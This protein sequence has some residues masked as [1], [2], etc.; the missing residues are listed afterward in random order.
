MRRRKPGLLHQHSRCTCHNES[1]CL[2]TRRTDDS[3]C[4]VWSVFCTNVDDY[5]D[6]M[7]NFLSTVF[8]PDTKYL[9]VRTFIEMENSRLQLRGTFVTETVTRLWPLCQRE[10]LFPFYQSGGSRNTYAYLVKIYAHI[11]GRRRHGS[12]QC[13]KSL[14]QILCIDWSG[15][16]AEFFFMKKKTQVSMP[17]MCYEIRNQLINDNSSVNYIFQWW[18]TISKIP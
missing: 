16:E 10:F 3:F 6:W 7:W 13:N 5:A 17:G 1:Q 12:L 8:P 4:D 2:G 11:S 15:A 9:A 14:H 18:L